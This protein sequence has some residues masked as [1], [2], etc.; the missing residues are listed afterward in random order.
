M[1]VTNNYLIKAIKHL[2]SV[3]EED[4][5]SKDVTDMILELKVSNLFIPAAEDD[6]DELIYETLIL[7][8]EEM[9]LLPLFTTEDEFYK[10]YDE[11]SEYKPVAYE[12][13]TYAE[14]VI[15]DDIS[16]IL[17][18]A[19]GICAKVPKDMV[20]MALADF[21]IDFSD[22]DTRS[23]KEIE[24]AYRTA[25]NDELLEFITD[26][27]NAEDYEGLFATLSG[28]FP[29]NIVV[30]EE[31]LDGFAKNGVIESDDVGGFSLYVV[32]YDGMG[33][34]AIFTDMDALSKTVFYEGVHYY[35]QLTKVSTLID[36]VLAFDM[37]GVIINPN[38]VNFIIPR[39]E[40][41][42][43]ASGIDVVVEDQSF[44]NCLDYAFLL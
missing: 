6:D 39:S 40:I 25:S 23:L 13:D 35:G 2:R 26:E 9:T 8:E 1:N 22:I 3:T 31:D 32:D 37:D 21:S 30:S 12:F 28:S 38:T 42:S 36:Y 43:Q 14:I 29:L 33:Y 34:G 11:D 18:D 15:E 20:E 5:V 24:S 10:F 16:G 27:S 7:G 19:E 44:R 41:L 17:I 4:I